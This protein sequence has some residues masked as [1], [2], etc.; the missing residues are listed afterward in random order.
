[1]HAQCVRSRS[2]FRL[3]VIPAKAGIQFL[4]HLST[5]SN[6][7]SVT[8]SFVVCWSAQAQR[9]RRCAELSAHALARGPFARFLK[10][11]FRVAGGSL[12]CQQRQESN[13]RSAAPM[14]A[15][16]PLSASL[17]SRPW[18][19]LAL[20]SN[21]QPGHP[22][23]GVRAFW[24]DIESL[25]KALTPARRSRSGVHRQAIHGLTLDASA[26]ALPRAKRRGPMSLRLCDARR[27]QTGE[28]QQ[29]K[30]ASKATDSTSANIGEEMLNGAD[31]RSSASR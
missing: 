25:H 13:Q 12:S 14:S 1:M 17:S 2:I 22:W 28:R 24:S 18:R 27:S 29:R 19:D 5:N 31:Q 20:I 30:A 8:S 11:R 4:F 9:S 16:N 21:P 15:P 26:P 23:P 7:C 3:A 6:A 10:V